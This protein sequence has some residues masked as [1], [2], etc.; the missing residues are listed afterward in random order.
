M[1]SPLVERWF[2]PLSYG[3][4]PKEATTGRPLSWS[5]KGR[6]WSRGKGDA[7]EDKQTTL[8][9]FKRNTRKDEQEEEERRRGQGGWS[10][11]TELKFS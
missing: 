1:A 4:V 11:A 9:A 6:A 2:Y 3:S 5:I 10:F 8:D 7:S